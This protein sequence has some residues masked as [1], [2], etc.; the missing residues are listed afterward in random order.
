MTE[1]I[2]AQVMD[3]IAA[4]NSIV[5]HFIRTTAGSDNLMDLDYVAEYMAPHLDD[6]SKLVRV[7]AERVIKEC[8]Y[9][10][11]VIRDARAQILEA[12]D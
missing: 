4:F 1:K 2:K 10:K 11:A 9:R 12:I 5:G 3:D 8:E 7:F 6:E